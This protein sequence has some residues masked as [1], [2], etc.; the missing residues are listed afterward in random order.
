MQDVQVRQVV[1]GTVD[2]AEILY[3]GQPLSEVP[4][5]KK[6]RFSTSLFYTEERVS[7]NILIAALSSVGHDIREITPKER[8]DFEVRTVTGAL[9]SLEVENLITSDLYITQQ[10]QDLSA[11]VSEWAFGTAEVASRLQ[12][13]QVSFVIPEYS[14]EEELSA[15]SEELK[16][17]LY[18]TDFSSVDTG[19]F[20]PVSSDYS[21]LSSLQARVLVRRGN[22]SFVQVTQ[23]ARAVA[24]PAVGA[25]E[26]I[27]HL[28]QY[29]AQAKARPSHASWLIVW[30]QSLYNPFSVGAAS[31]LLREIDIAPYDQIIVA[32]GREIA[33]IMP[34]ASPE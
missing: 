30:F 33:V 25:Y 27:Q 5:F 13:I 31:N 29:Q 21:V 24:S 19:R 20:G 1:V 7:A 4:R 18:S 34:S 9:L 16:R 8:S 12:G 6:T 17:Y 28:R 2:E 3:R 10:I 26:V 22:S 23:G 11:G 32:D 15:A 14:R